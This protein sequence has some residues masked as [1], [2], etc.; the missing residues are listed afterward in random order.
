MGG[1]SHVGGAASGWAELRAQ[2]ACF[3]KVGEKL[4]NTGAEAIGS[5]CEDRQMSGRRVLG[6][7][8][9]LKEQ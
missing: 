9:G 7:W 5:D 4:K 8:K 2:R 3:R 1:L 6:E